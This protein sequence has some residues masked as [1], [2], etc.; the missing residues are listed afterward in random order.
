M[1]ILRERIQIRSCAPDL[2]FCLRLIAA[3]A[4]VYLIWGSTYLA[5]RLAIDTL[6]PFSMAG[7]RFFLAGT[8]LYGWMRLRRAAPPVRIHWR[9]AA[10][11]GGLML[12][13]G[14]GGVT[15]AEQSVPS[16]L[17]A[18]LI[19]TVPLWMVIL[20]AMR[21]GGTRP[22]GRMGVGLALGLAGIFL[23]VGPVNLAGGEGVDP[24]GAGVLLVAA[25]SWAGGSLYSRQAQLPA[26]PLL[27]TAMEML[28]GGAL[29][30]LV[31]GLSGEWARLDLAAVSPRSLLALGYLVLFGS[32]LG[33][34]AYLWLLRNTTPARAST[35]AYINP[36]IAVLLG[37]AVL[38][39]LLTWQTLLGA[40][41]VVSAVVLINTGRVQ[42]QGEG[43][44]EGA[45]T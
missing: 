38:D 41:V 10:I 3:F 37:W 4:A 35:Y 21:P 43:G 26:A 29:L 33:F 44:L 7:F 25:L 36:M 16:G 28:A 6:P 2:G 8:L 30:L 20:E 9:S 45:E 22:T 12:L 42:S 27:G 13:G 5:I 14:N 31:G 32:L 19:G 17:A 40:A 24:V 23:L 11:V 1:S 18:L 34:T 39:E 15:W